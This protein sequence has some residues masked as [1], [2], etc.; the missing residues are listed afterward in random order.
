MFVEKKRLFF[1]KKLS[2]IHFFFQNFKML[3]NLKG[4][5]GQSSLT[6]L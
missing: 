4:V 2:E 6:K 3:L 1:Y 5:K